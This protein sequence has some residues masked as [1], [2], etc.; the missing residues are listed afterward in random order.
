M[1]DLKPGSEI[2]D[3]VANDIPDD[4]AGPNEKDKSPEP[5]PTTTAVK[6]DM[7]TNMLELCSR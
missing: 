6:I 5:G 2:A 1:K 4:T 3:P 7:K